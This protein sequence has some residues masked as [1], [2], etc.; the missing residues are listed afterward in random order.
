MPHLCVAGML[1]P[2]ELEGCEYCKDGRGLD[3][4]LAEIT[5]LKQK[6]LDE[7]DALKAEIARLKAEMEWLKRFIAAYDKWAL[8][9][10]WNDEF[11]CSMVEARDELP[12]VKESL[13]DQLKQKDESHFPKEGERNENAI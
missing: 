6:W 2:E 5:T 12:D 1:V 11:F 3:S 7:V 10:D 8:A 9:D 13:T 4:Q